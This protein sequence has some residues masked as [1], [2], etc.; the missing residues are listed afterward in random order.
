MQ[1]QLYALRIVFQTVQVPAC[2]R[3]F[4]PRSFGALEPGP[5]RP[6]A[7]RDVGAPS[8]SSRRRGDDV[9]L[10]AVSTKEEMDP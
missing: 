7:S 1:L 2:L 10:S 5:I 4:F 3:H 8:G 9:D 6:L